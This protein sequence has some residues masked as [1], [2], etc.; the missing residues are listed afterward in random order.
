MKRV[1]WQY[2]ESWRPRT[3]VTV[4]LVAD[5]MELWFKGIDRALRIPLSL[6]ES[7]VVEK[8]EKVDLSAAQAPGAAGL[9]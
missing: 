5:T 9:R 2:V 4:A 1:V 8:L 6:P 7:V 3:E